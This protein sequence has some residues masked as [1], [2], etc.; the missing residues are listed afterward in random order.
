MKRKIITQIGSLPYEDIGEAVEYSLKHD[1]PFLPELPKKGDLMLNYI[2]N[3][4]RL[5]CLNEFKKHKYTTVKIQCIGPATL[6]L[7]R[8]SKDE[9]VKRT[10]EHISKIID[11]LKAE[12]ILLFLD[13]PALEQVGFNYRELWE[14]LFTSFNVISGIHTCGNINLD[15]LFNSDIKIIS[16][17]ASQYNITKYLKY[18]HDKRIAWGIERRE[19][20]RNFQEGDLLTLPCGMSPY[21]YR[22][23]DCE[24][25]LEMLVRVSKEVLS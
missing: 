15:D 22:V 10:Y 23:E 16:F 3:P 18:R 9:A 6:I 21:L 17:D 12:E 19:D 5:S 4:G 14:P 2:K 25:N 13:E 24:K 7:N 8:Y 11:G 1:I 20:V